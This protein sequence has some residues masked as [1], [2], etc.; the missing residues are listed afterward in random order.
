MPR[1][2]LVHVFQTS[3]LNM[4]LCISPLSRLTLNKMLLEAKT[5]IHLRLYAHC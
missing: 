3:Y 1:N 2:L 5:S 4:V